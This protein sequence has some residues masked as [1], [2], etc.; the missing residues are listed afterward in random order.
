MIR[1]PVTIPISYQLEPEGALPQPG[2]QLSGTRSSG[3]GSRK[4]RSSLS[5]LSQEDG[6]LP[7]SFGVS[8]RPIHYRIG[9]TVQISC[10]TVGH[11]FLLA[12]VRRAIRTVAL[13]DLHVET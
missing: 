6:S 10:G 1:T 9:A 12:R 8:H 2:P 4:K 13:S 5:E 11:G 3:R 7:E